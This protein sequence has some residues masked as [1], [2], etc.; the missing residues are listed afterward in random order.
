MGDRN[1]PCEHS[2][3]VTPEVCSPLILWAASLGPIEARVKHLDV[4]SAESIAC[5][6]QMGIEGSQVPHSCASRTASWYSVGL[7]AS[8]R[9]SVLFVSKDLGYIQSRPASPLMLPKLS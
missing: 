7:N 5:M 3:R 2:N 6:A 9:N 1:Q 8:A 4:G